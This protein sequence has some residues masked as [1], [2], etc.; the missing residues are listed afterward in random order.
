MA[1]ATVPSVH[2]S[3]GISEHEQEIY[4]PHCFPPVEDMTRES[5]SGKAHVIDQRYN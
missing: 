3:L 1:G 2:S 5:T 4:E